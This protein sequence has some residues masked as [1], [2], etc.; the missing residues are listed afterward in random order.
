MFPF[1]AWERFAISPVGAGSLARK[2]RRPGGSADAVLDKV[3][4]TA[5]L[6]TDRVHVLRQVIMC[7]RKAGAVSI[8][9]G[10]CRDGED[11]SLGP[12]PQ[13]LR[14]LRAAIWPLPHFYQRP[15]QDLALESIRPTF[16]PTHNQSYRAKAF[17]VL[18]NYLTRSLSWP[19]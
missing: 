1:L 17:S 7:C 18:F 14:E 5:F 6:A 13:F 15:H 2:R 11:N 8:P 19:R 4:A 16:G 10:L 3:K 9:G 12:I